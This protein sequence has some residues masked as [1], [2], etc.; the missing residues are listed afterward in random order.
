MSYNF[1]KDIRELRWPKYA[2]KSNGGM[3]V[4]G[5]MPAMNG[6][7]EETPYDGKNLLNKGLE[8]QEIN[9]EGLGGKDRSLT[10]GGVGLDSNSVG[11]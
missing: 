4:T 3:G 2:E 10:Q 9:R 8:K 5:E 7:N 1:S 6:S 11:H